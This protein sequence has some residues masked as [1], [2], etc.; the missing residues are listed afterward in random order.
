LIYYKGVSDTY[1]YTLQHVKRGYWGTTAAVRKAGE[2][3]TSCKPTAIAAWLPIFSYRTSMPDYYAK[4]LIKNGMHYIDFDGKKEC[5]T[6]AMGN[7][8]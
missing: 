6:R 5:F 1:P 4:V 8:R 3:Y 7:I 2:T